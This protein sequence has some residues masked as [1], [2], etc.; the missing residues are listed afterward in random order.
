[1]RLELVEKYYSSEEY[2]R[3]LLARLDTLRQCESDFQTARLVLDIWSVNPIEFIETFLWVKMPN[4][5]NAIKPFFLFDY[6]KEIIMKIWECEQDTLEH[7]ILIDKPREMG[8]TYTI[9]AYLYWRW[10]FTADH[11]SFILS[12]TEDEVD[13]GEDT[14][15]GSLFGKMRW[16]IGMTPKFMIPTSF[17][18]KGKKGTTTDRMLSLINPSIKSSISGSTTNA[19]AGRSRR[20]SITF[21]DECFFIENFQQIIRS[22]ESV[23]RVKVLASST[24]EGRQFQKFK[25]MCANRGDYISLTYDKH[26]W[27]DK[28]WYDNLVKKAEEM[29]DPEIMREAVVSYAIDPKSRYYPQIEEARM[30]PVK[31]DPKRPLYVS[32]DTGRSDRTVLLWWQYTGVNFNILDAVSNKNR[33]IDWYAPYLNPDLE[34]NPDHY[35][36]PAHIDPLLRVRKWEKPMYLFSGLDAKAKRMPTNKSIEQH[37]YPLIQMKIIV[38]PYAE[39]HN[40]RHTALSMLLPLMVFNEDSQ[41]ATDCYD[42]IANSKYASAT[43]ATSK[44]SAMAPVHG[45]DGNADWRSAAEYGATNIVRAVR[46]QRTEPRSEKVQDTMGILSKFLRV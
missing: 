20:Y 10:L 21:I 24:Q 30:A 34:Y 2:K 16:M 43:R 32:M 3:R 35:K 31:Y 12:R 41:G 17:Q 19:S 6:Q 25:E 11:S 26:P 44:K 29:D 42:A 8:V 1:M 15:D 13:K 14:P 33:D 22:L 7:T 28:Q 4:Y 46:M 37:L 45:T 23:S 18:P 39:D 5:N 9:L 38:N 36:L 40:S 27:K